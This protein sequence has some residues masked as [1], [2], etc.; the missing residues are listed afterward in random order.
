MIPARRSAPLGVS[1]PLSGGWYA[2]PTPSVD[3]SGRHLLLTGANGSRL[4]SRGMIGSKSLEYGEHAFKVGLDIF[5]C[6]A[7]DVVAL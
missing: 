2:A 4:F 7:E 6:E 5:V 1:E 3:R